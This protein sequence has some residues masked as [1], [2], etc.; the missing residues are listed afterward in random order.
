MG[1]YV[2]R[3]FVEVPEEVLSQILSDAHH[4][5][6]DR[7]EDKCGNLTFEQLD[8]IMYQF[9][10]VRRE[11]AEGS[12][13]TVEGFTLNRKQIAEIADELARGQFISAIKAFRMAT[14]AGLREAKEMMDQFG[15]GK[16][17][18]IR[19]MMAFN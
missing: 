8:E 11:M 15:N 1:K 12:H 18:S 2:Y 3:T 7:L 9:T 4:A 14:G 10:V 5:L 19:F 13:K 17:G 16:S 6:R